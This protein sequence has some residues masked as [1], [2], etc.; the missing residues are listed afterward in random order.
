MSPTDPCA[1][2]SFEQP[3]SDPPDPVA[4][5]Y[6]ALTEAGHVFFVDSPSFLELLIRL[7]G[8]LGLRRQRGGQG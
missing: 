6:R 8:T 2:P 3:T 5:I 4:T 1:A 7:G